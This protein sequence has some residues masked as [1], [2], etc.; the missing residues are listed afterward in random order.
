MGNSNHKD[1][2]KNRFSNV[3]V[4]EESLDTKNSIPKVNSPNSDLDFKEEL[5]QTIDLPIENEIYESN[6]IALEDKS[7]Q[8]KNFIFSEGE[9]PPTSDLHYH[10]FRSKS[11]VLNQNINISLFNA[12][13]QR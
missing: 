8:I 7:E 1:H 6:E 2:F 12:R 9:A 11:Y 10:A 5:K 3:C 4:F 13:N